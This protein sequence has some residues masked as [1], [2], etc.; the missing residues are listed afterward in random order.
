MRGNYCKRRHAAGG[1]KM[2]S[3]FRKAGGGFGIP[4]TK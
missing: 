3:F 2:E 1:A 4:V